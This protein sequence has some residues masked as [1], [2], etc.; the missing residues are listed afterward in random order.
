[1]PWRHHWVGGTEPRALCWERISPCTSG[2]LQTPCPSPSCL[3]H[4]PDW[5]TFTKQPTHILK[6]AVRKGYTVSYS[7]IYVLTLNTL[8]ALEELPLAG[9]GCLALN[10]EESNFK[11][12][13]VYSAI[14]QQGQKEI[15]TPLTLAREMD[16]SVRVK[17]LHILSKASKAQGNTEE[18]K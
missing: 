4:Q 14:L 17:G 18:A 10:Q 16:T 15:T 8:K 9:M 2:W 13:P 7:R 3:H 5:H 12:I 11:R 6:K 1:M